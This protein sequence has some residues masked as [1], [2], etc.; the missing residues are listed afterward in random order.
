[1][2][3][4]TNILKC[5]ISERFQTSVKKVII[6]NIPKILVGDVSFLYVEDMHTR[7]GLYLE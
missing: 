1:M 6:K 2:I 7:I 3:Y 4:K 5:L